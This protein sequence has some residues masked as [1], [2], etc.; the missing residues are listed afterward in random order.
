MIVSILNSIFNTNYKWWN[1]EHGKP[2][3]LDI[4]SFC[5]CYKYLN[6]NLD[7]DGGHSLGELMKLEYTISNLNDCTDS[8][9]DLK[10]LYEFSHD[11]FQSFKININQDF[12]FNQNTS[13]ILE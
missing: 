12:K 4:E 1:D 7:I 9:V 6:Y 8:L 11:L 13:M 5:S 10:D 3:P 2:L